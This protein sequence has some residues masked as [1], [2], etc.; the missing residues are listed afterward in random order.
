MKKN[1]FYTFAGILFGIILTKSEVISW[2][3]IQ[4]M[5]RFEEPYMY[6]IIGSAVV[7]GA[8][9]VWLLKSAAITS[10]DGQALDFSGKT[11]H[12]GFIWGGLI[13]GIGWAITG[14]CPGPI[15]AQ[16]ASGAYPAIFTLIGALMGAY[17][18][19]VFKSK[20]PH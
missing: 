5:F 20:L 7:I 14:A 19:H 6:L 15:F 9:S 10:I 8:I 4:N 13:F 17:M 3:R 11:Y 12:R 18:Y 1:I 16:V 2:F